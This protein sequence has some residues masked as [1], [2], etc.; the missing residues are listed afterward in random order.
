MQKIDAKNLPTY[1]FVFFLLLF[2]IGGYFLASDYGVSWDSLMQMAIGEYNQAY[3]S[4]ENFFH[5]SPFIFPGHEKYYGP[6]HEIVIQT[7]I[8]IFHYF[9]LQAASLQLMYWM[10]FSSF[11]L[12]IFFFY[13]LARRFMRTW[14]AVLSSLLFFSQPLLFGHA[15]INSK[16]IPFLSF[17]VA[18]IFLGIKMIEKLEHALEM[19]S[20]QNTELVRFSFD[21]WRKAPAKKKRVVRRSL[22]V[23][24]I[25]SFLVLILWSTI[26]TWIGF[27]II[28]LIER[29]DL[30]RFWSRFAE[31]AD[32]IPVD[33]Y[34]H[35]GRVLFARVVRMSFLVSLFAIVIAAIRSVPKMMHKFWHDMMKIFFVEIFSKKY[36]RNV[37]H[38]LLNQWV[39]LAGIS[40]GITTS[41]RVLGPAA[42][43]LVIFVFMW[44][45]KEKSLAPITAYLLVLIFT[46]YFTWPLVWSVGFEGIIDTF[47][48]M[49]DF[50]WNSMVLFNG[51]LYQSS[52]LPSLYLPMLLTI[53]LT[54]PV[55]I[56]FFVGLFL[57]FLPKTQEKISSPLLWLLLL[58]F[59]L[60]L[61]GIILFKPN[62]YDNFR[63]FL[64]ILP[65]IFVI[66][67]IGLDWLLKK[68]M[69]K[70]INPLIALGILLPGILAIF[71][72]HPYEYAYYNGF[73]GGT[74]GAFRRFEMDYWAI[75]I[76]EA[77]NFVNENAPPNAKIL[78]AGPY[79]NV[80]WR[81]RNDLEIFEIGDIEKERHKEYDYA[82]LTSRGNAD[83]EYLTDFPTV[84]QVK[85]KNVVY[86]VVREIKDE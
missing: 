35:K 45:K 51:M 2:F 52:A 9:G 63:Q 42:A 38:S 23:W 46:T 10:N 20:I 34:V 77:I 3:F 15:F 72:L 39:F 71:T 37:G 16:D 50:P 13:H 6:I 59:F 81:G 86:I 54:E 29:E 83:L 4:F 30:T 65:P 64:F 21:E 7:V 85:K 22:W 62:I 28:K 43:G 41:I 75:S 53:Q 27:I 74:N 57:L 55:V 12:G 32:T 40:T 47:R 79:Q 31:N 49:S 56:F 8:D 18:S 1:I 70:W 44:R 60:P 25:G 24:S 84:F 14:A 67:G 61:A 73:V 69:F 19:S 58:W 5:P 80:Q 11:L 33:A 68:T 78:V 48:V 76:D 36:V 26:S 17:F 82:I 66:A